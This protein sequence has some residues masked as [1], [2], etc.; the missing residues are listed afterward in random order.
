MRACSSPCARNVS[1]G[2]PRVLGRCK[3]FVTPPEQPLF[4]LETSEQRTV[5]PWK[6]G[7]S[8]PISV[9]LLQPNDV[10]V[11]GNRTLRSRDPGPRPARPAR[12]SPGSSASLCRTLGRRFRSPPLRGGSQGPRKAAPLI[13]PGTLIYA[14]EMQNE[15][16]FLPAHKHTFYGT[17]V[18]NP[19]FDTNCQ[20]ARK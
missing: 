8:G 12:T 1:T 19:H 9:S 4:L 10:C 13:I 7:Q 15:A 3:F 20:S 18:S 11:Q 16:Y 5:R 17:R 6:N 14:D 2:R